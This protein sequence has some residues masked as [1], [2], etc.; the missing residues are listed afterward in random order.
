MQNNY[1]PHVE[2]QNSTL[3]M[4]LSRAVFDSFSKSMGN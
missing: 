2:S 1:A 4:P 3:G